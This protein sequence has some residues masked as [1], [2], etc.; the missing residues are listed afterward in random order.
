[1]KK[2]AALLLLVV[3][4]AGAC[5]QKPKPTSN[6]VDREK[7]QS[8]TSDLIAQAGLPA[9]KN[10]RELKLVND[11]YEM[12][13]QS[14]LVTY[15]YTRN[16]FTGK[17]VWFC[18]S[19]GYPIPYATQRSAPESMQTY[20][21]NRDGRPDDYGTARLPQPEPNGLFTPGSAEGTWVRCTNPDTGDENFVY[22]EPKLTTLQWKLPDW[23]VEG[24]N[25]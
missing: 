14:G 22:S 11:L 21:V 12:R 18:A 6:D 9:V 23:Q 2:R 16:D 20:R 17:F 8:I 1:M 19:I 10:G 24:Q 5:T 25:G 4:L 15:T 7:Q 13:D 3:V